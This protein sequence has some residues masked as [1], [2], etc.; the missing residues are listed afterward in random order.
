VPIIA[1]LKHCLPRTETEPGMYIDRNE[2]FAKHDAS[3]PI[4]VGSGS[5]FTESIPIPKKRDAGRIRIALGIR[6]D[7]N[8]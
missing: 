2:L 6:I 7:G 4:N 5:N 8:E 1:S 3:I